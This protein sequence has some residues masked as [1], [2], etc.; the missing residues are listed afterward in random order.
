M[1]LKNYII[2]KIYLYCLKNPNQSSMEMFAVKPCFLEVNSTL[3]GPNNFEISQVS[4]YK[5]VKMHN[6]TEIGTTNLFH[7]IPSISKISV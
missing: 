2:H 1:Q 4:R 3:T 5:V 7:Y 6:D